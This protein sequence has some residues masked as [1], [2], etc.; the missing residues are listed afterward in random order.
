[1][2]M[3]SPDANK[4]K[5]TVSINLQTA[6]L[7]AMLKA[8]TDANSLGEVVDEAI[9]AYHLVLIETPDMEKKDRQEAVARMVKKLLD[10]N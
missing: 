7:L 3:V 8:S 2:K 6:T 9:E 5:I 4:K 10:R 1:M